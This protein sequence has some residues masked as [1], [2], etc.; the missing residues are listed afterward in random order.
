M[1]E[2]LYQ[3]LGIAKT[4]TKDEIKKAYR[5]KSQKHHPDA[6]GDPAKF[7]EI[8]LA[9]RILTDEEKRARYDNGESAESMTSAQKT[10]EQEAR[11]ILIRLFIEVVK[12]CDPD[13]TDLIAK[14]RDQV[15]HGMKQMGKDEAEQHGIVERWRKVLKRLK[16]GEECPLRMTANATIANAEKQLLEIARQRKLGDRCIEFLTDYSYEF[17]PS[18]SVILNGVNLGAINISLSFGG[19]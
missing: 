18:H 11:E 14:L 2:N 7:R 17:E 9:Y 10:E 1:S 12:H 6:G 8:N 5:K 15:N 4:A 3:D 16:S 19:P 13:R